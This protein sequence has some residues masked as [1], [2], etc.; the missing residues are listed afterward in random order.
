MSLPFNAAGV[1]IAVDDYG[2]VLVAQRSE[3]PQSEYF[4]R[5]L[6]E[7]GG[8]PD[9]VLDYS[10][11]GLGLTKFFLAPALGEIYRV[12]RLLVFIEDTK[13]IADQYGNISGGLAVG[14]KLTVENSI[15]GVLND[16]MDGETVQ[17]SAGWAK[18]CFDADLK[19]WGVGNEFLPVRWTFTKG[20]VYLRLVGDDDERLVITVNDDLTG[21]DD[22]EFLAQGYIE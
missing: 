15:G 19:A 5:H 4:C 7:I 21:L 17:T 12:A 20:G 1:N 2:A 13:I 3:G 6:R 16:L 22:H 14:V 8:S 9:A 10:G 11:G 18:Y